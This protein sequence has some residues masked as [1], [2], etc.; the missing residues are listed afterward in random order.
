MQEKVKKYIL[1]CWQEVSGFDI[2]GVVE[3]WGGVFSTSGVS[4]GDFRGASKLVWKA[5]SC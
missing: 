2:Q 3:G 5:F 1:G 4:G